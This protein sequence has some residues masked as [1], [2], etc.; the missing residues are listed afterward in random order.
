MGQFWNFADA[1][2]F[3]NKHATILQC[4]LRNKELRYEK[5]DH[6]QN[7]SLYISIGHDGCIASMTPM[8]VDSL[9]SDF[10]SC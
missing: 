3:P 5:L 6:S 1:N 7:D 2:H 4:R 9:V 10:P 8:R